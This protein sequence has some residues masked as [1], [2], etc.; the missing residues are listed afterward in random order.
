MVKTKFPIFCIFLIGFVLFAGT[1][2]YA[3][4][5]KAQLEKEKKDIQQRIA[6]N[7]KILTQIG[8]DRKN[9]I[10]QLNVINSQI[11][12]QQKLIANV[13]SELS[14]L[15]RQIDD[16]SMIIDALEDDL[17]QLKAEYAAMLYAAQKSRSLTSKMAF[18]FASRS[19]NQLVMRL[20]Y[21][22]YYSEMRTNQVRQIE[23]VKSTLLT[24]RKQVEE[25]RTEQKK[26]LKEQ[27]ERSVQL[28]RLK[29]QQSGV[30]TQLSAREREIRKDIDERKKAV[31]NL[32]KL[33]AEIIRKEIERNKAKTD[34]K[35]GAT[36]ADK[37]ISSNFEGNKTRLA[38]P[39]NAGFISKKFGVHPHP[40]FKNI[41]EPNDGVDIQ[42]NKDEPVRAVFEGVV[43]AVAA[44]PNLGTTVILQHGEYYS[45][46]ANLKSTN[47]KKGQKVGTKEELGIV[48]TD[49]DGVSVLQFQ[50]WKNTTKLNPEDWLARK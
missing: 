41:K 17:A 38:W 28:E 21:L 30:I 24:Q 39:V 25:K 45:V 9:T 44:I 14:L 37:L 43:M 13:N 35:V 32:E 42:T 7:E 3:Q 16:I 33:I 5:S 10:G 22:E 8:T 47:V 19:F 20:K 46:Y 29:A 34:S 1:A 36:P 23:A 50:I 11:E 6:E 4:K 49:K 15:E 27:M 48:R 12:Q 18:L 2:V 40:V 26:V 31:G